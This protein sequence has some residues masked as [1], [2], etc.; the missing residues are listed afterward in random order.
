MTNHYFKKD[1]KLKVTGRYPPVA[2][3]GPILGPVE[4][5]LRSCLF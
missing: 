4:D 3:K 1:F 2:L 5:S